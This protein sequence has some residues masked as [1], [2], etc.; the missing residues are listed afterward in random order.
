MTPTRLGKYEIVAKIGQGAMGEVYK[1]VDPV[2]GREVAVKTMSREIG[3]DPEL[4]RRFHREAQQAGRLNH[5]NVITV[6][7]YGEEQGQVYIAMELLEG[8]DLKDLIASGHRLS[9][10]EK[11]SLMEQMAEGLAFAHSRGVVHRDLK[12]ANIHVQP[13]GQ[14]K[15]MDFGLARPAKSDM[16]RA[17][18]IMGTPN[19]MSPEQVRGETATAQS[20][21]FSLGAVF[22][23]LLTSR[24]AFAGEALHA[25]LYQVMQEHPEPLE[26]VCPEAPTALREVVERA[27]A[28]DKGVR[29]RD[30]GELREA[31]RATREALGLAPAPRESSGRLPATSTGAFSAPTPR[32]GPTLPRSAGA[33]ALEPTRVEPDRVDTVRSQA[34]TLAEGEAPPTAVVPPTEV[35]PAPPARARADRPATRPRGEA[36][37]PWLA[38]GAAGGVALAAAAGWSLL[39]RAPASG[40]APQPPPTVAASLPTPPPAAAVMPSPPS[41]PPS[42]DAFLQTGRRRLAEKDW[43]AAR[44]AAEAAL[45]RAPGDAA[46]R[47]L[48]GE[49]GAGTR[50][51]DA[52]ALTAATALDSGD[53]QSAS[54]ALQRLSEQ[55]PRNP[56][57]PTLSRRLSAELGRLTREAQRR[58]TPAPTAMAAAATPTPTPPLPAPPLVAPPSL[59]SAPP[60]TTVAAAALTP[61]QIEASRIAIGSTLEGYRAAFET[62]NAGALRAIYPGVD[63]EHHRELFARVQSYRVKLQVQEVQVDG[64]QGLARC[65]VTYTPKPTPAGKNPPRPQVFH[66]RRSGETWIIDRVESGQ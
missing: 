33:V 26:R 32:P 17:G 51:G 65:L 44:A 41:S 21:V 53:A 8:W 62:R 37:P 22:Y 18:S 35:R 5:P 56:Q 10:G 15:I 28:K 11:F 42:I 14:V 66:L 47:A 1:A 55:D 59:P 2:L 43:R 19:Y 57:I 45:T 48:L 25:V 46:A 4:R 13:G 39:S 49:A 61:A 64:D 12:P 3:A 6:Y 38:L 40:P 34:P 24:K 9:I 29:Y 60:P 31:L 58:P 52:T 63:Y 27:L 20:D 50:E 23:E 36:R 7:D 30:A 54:S 16:T